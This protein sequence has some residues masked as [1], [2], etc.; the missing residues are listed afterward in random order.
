MDLDFAAEARALRRIPPW[1][2][3]GPE[4]VTGRGRQRK[5]RRRDVPPQCVGISA[6]S[7]AR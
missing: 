3:G 6:A 7:Y 1:L 4:L 2:R 5:R